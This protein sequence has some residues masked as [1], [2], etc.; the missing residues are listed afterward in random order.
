MNNI[1]KIK[2]PDEL[3]LQFNEQKYLLP[4]HEKLEEN[5]SKIENYLKEDN[6]LEI[7]KLVNHNNI[8]LLRDKDFMNKLPN[9]LTSH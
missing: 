8:I 6:V 2:I 1:I 4:K 5:I 3:K 7:I 9:G